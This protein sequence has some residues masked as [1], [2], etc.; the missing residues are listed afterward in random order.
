MSGKNP[1]VNTFHDSNFKVAISN[2][3]T[4]EHINELSLYHNFIRS[5]SL[6]GFSIDMLTSDW[7]GEQ[8]LH[9]GNHKNDDLGDITITFKLTEDLMNYFYMAQYIMDMRYENADNTD[10]DP[11]D[12]MKMNFIKAIDIMILDNSKRRVANI[13]FSRC[14][15]TNISTLDLDYTNGNE[16]DFTVT[17]KFT[18]IHFAPVEI[19]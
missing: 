3:P 7:R 1:T 11:K 4:L 6:P 10:D 2:V 14:F 8:S 13:K 9:P 16:V 15:P 17:F 19:N 12:R 5:V 18:E